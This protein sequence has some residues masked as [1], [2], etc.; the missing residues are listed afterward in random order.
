M[1]RSPLTGA[2]GD[3]SV[4]GSLGFQLKKAG[5]D[6]IGDGPQRLDHLRGELSYS[7]KFKKSKTGIRRPEQTD[8]VSHNKP[9]PVFC[10]QG[11]NALCRDYSH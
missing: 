5:F 10:R 4:G 11:L 2:V 7:Q 8:G 9:H 1:S 3:S 6:G